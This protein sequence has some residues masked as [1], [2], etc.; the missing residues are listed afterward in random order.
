[1]KHIFSSHASRIGYWNDDVDIHNRQ[2][3]PQYVEPLLHAN[4]LD[5]ESVLRRDVDKSADTQS[6]R[7]TG[8]RDTPII[9]VPLQ[10]RA[11]LGLSADDNNPWQVSHRKGA[12]YTR[13]EVGRENSL[14]AR[15]N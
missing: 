5:T 9:P 10:S 4:R 13:V 14:V 12:D 7:Q 15:T 8:E 3:K 11:E 6:R 1:M 2:T